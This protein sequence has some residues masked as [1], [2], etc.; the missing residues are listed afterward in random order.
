MNTIWII[1]AIVGIIITLFR[2]YLAVSDSKQQIQANEHQQIVCN[3]KLKLLLR[4]NSLHSDISLVS[5][6]AAVALD[7]TAGILVCISRDSEENGIIIPLTDLEEVQLEDHSDHYRHALEMEGYYS[8]IH[9]TS[10]Y[11][12]NGGHK[13]EEVKQGH[14]DYEAY[15]GNPVYGIEIKCRNGETINVPLYCGDGTLFWTEGKNLNQARDFIRVLEST[16]SNLQTGTA[17]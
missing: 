16:I 6:F 10:M 5:S 15:R 4:T 9:R 8:K 14:K 17:D 2:Q 11:S 7:K 12:P 3:E 1:V 13:W